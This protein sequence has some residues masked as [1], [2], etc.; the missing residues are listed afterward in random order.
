MLTWIYLTRSSIRPEHD[1][2]NNWRCV[3][4]SSCRSEVVQYSVGP[5]CSL[6]GSSLGSTT[7]PGIG[8]LALT[9]YLWQRFCELT[10]PFA[11]PRRLPSALTTQN[12]VG[13]PTGAE[14]QWASRLLWTFQSTLCS[15]SVCGCL[16]TPIID[17]PQGKNEKWIHACLQPT[18]RNSLQLPPPGKYCSLMPPA[19]SEDPIPAHYL[20][21][22]QDFCCIEL[23]IVG[24]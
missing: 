7:L 11:D 10:G 3:N 21:L 12:V 16:V 8:I 13:V 18:E 1:V 20:I 5:A 4:R 22:Q 9:V 15:L 24:W 14:Y 2:I 23:V 17:Y 6:L 19:T